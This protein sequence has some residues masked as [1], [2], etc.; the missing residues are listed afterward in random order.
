MVG[1]IGDISCSN[2]NTSLKLD[3]WD[4]IM[5]MWENDEKI[6]SC[7]E[8]GDKDNIIIKC[9]HCEFEKVRLSDNHCED[10]GIDLELY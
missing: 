10:C 6:G 2:C 1:V 4:E 8:C 3:Y 9:S 5:E 7:P